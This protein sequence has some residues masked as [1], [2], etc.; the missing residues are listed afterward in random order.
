MGAAPAIPCAVILAAGRGNRL[1]PWTADRPKCLLPVGRRAILEHQIR[2]LRLAG[3]ESIQVITGHGAERVRE[4]I[5]GTASYA[6]NADYDRT[7]SLDTLG[8]ASVPISEAGLLVLNSD[9][10]FHPA[11]L[12]RLL[13]DPRPNVLLADFRA[14]L[15]EEEMKIVA[16]ESGRILEISKTMDPRLAQAENLGVLRLSREAAARMIELA[17][18]KSRDKAIQW[19]PDG[20]QSLRGEFDFFALATGGLP[21]IEIDYPH[22][23]SAANE[24]IYPQ[25]REALWGGHAQGA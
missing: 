17:R 3:V 15:G 25:L 1:L 10:L 22:D 21:W 24:A 9:V 11:L 19:A 6:H 16:D 13:A 18:D 20:I 8:F 12:A 2:A 14:G 23:L 4:L 5:D 7:N